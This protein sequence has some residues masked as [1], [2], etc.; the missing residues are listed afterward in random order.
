M[1]ISPLVRGGG[2]V[3]LPEKIFE[4]RALLCAFLMGVLCVLDPVLDSHKLF[5]YF[6]Q[7]VSLTLFHLCTRR[8]W[9]ST[10]ST[11]P[12]W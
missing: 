9:Q 1:I 10:F 2:V 4:F 8:F 5:F 3:G 12:W 11:D 6:L 7:H